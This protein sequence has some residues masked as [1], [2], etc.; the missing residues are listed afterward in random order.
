[1]LDAFD[2]HRD[3]LADAPAPS[4]LRRALGWA[5]LEQRNLGRVVRTRMQG[6]SS[7]AYTAHKFPGLTEEALAQRIAKFRALD[8]TL[9][10]MRVL[11]LKESIFALERAE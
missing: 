5:V 4:P 9:P 3:R 6:K 10:K 8:P 11:K 1:M 7:A 2:T